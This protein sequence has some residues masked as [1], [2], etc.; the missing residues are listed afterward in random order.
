MNNRAGFSQRSQFVVICH[1]DGGITLLGSIYYAARYHI[2]ED[3]NLDMVGD[4]NP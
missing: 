2:P 4:L 1:E 3:S